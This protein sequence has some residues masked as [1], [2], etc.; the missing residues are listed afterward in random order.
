MPL[1]VSS[2]LVLIFRRSKFYHA[3]SGIITPAGDRPV[4]RLREDSNLRRESFP[5]DVSG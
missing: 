3:L 1:H 4:H 2:T 5:T